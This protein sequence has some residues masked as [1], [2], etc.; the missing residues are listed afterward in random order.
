MAGTF[1]ILDAV[2]V[3]MRDGTLLP[4]DIWLPDGNGPWPVLLQRTPYRREDVHGAQYISALEFQSALRRGFAVMV[5]DTRGRYAAGGTF[6][7]FTWEEE[8]GADTI[9]WLRAQSFC[10]G[11]VAMFGASYVGATQVLAAAAH[12]EGLVAISP[13]LTTARH[14]ETWMY[15]SGAT[16][17]GF[18][19]LWIIEALG[20]P[21]LERRIA[22]M[23]EA[24]A[25]RLCTYFA[26]LMRDPDAAF[27]HLPLLDADL[28]GL[29]P[30]AGRWFDDER[31]ASALQNR[32]R[33]D[34]IAASDA[35]MLV[36]A[37]WN[38]LFLEGSLEL[39]E[40]VRRRHSNPE[41]VRDRLIIGPWSHGNPK[42]W[43]GAFWHGYAAST[44]GLSD[45]QID[46]FDAALNGR[47][48]TGPMVRYFRSGS[49]TWHSAPDWPLPGTE[50]KPLYLV[51]EHL[52]EI[53]TN[54]DWS[55]TYMSNPA[56]P[57]PT[58]GG[59]TFLPGLLLGR[60][61]G[62]MEQSNIERRDDVLVFTSAPLDA[63]VEVTGLVKATLWVQSSAVSSDWTA[64]LCEVHPDGRSF[65]LVDGITR[66]SNPGIDTPVEITV[67]LGHIGHLFRAGSRIR[68]QV[69]SSN[70]PRFD[71]NP[72]SRVPAT[73]ATEA[74]F[75]IAQQAL[76]GGSGRQSYVSL[77][78]VRT[79]NPS[80]GVLG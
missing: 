18:L 1:K 56:S 47:P 53:A 61:A 57:V 54:T 39:F 13:Q 22:T 44:A 17:L 58:T 15:R 65:G 51:G 74:D 66:W 2:A 5:Q 32:E 36:T 55:R 40:T 11:Q 4:A 29:A 31:A 16:E 59:A 28:L 67:R 64:R 12:P 41:N 21:D 34:A 70:F 60:N 49:N 9:A 38:D 25:N 76:L 6:D 14:G 52:T 10:D 3:P 79:Q 35:A 69:A 24:T 26:T 33:L 78:V 46:F 50:I 7:P 48:A 20:A 62:P 30:Y 27:A 42:D 72:Q 68:L 37:G 23:D 43:Q 75:V 80:I 8:D 77:P 71:R 45:I 19:L 73:L 63:E